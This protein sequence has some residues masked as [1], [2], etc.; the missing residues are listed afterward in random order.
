MLLRLRLLQGPTSAGPETD[1]TRQD[2]N[3]GLPFDIITTWMSQ[4][5]SRVQY[6]GGGHQLED[7]SEADENARARQRIQEVTCNNKEV[8]KQQGDSR[9][10]YTR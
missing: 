2:V 10:K 8:K 9:D 1:F 6:Q 3:E 4:G 7:G 5:A